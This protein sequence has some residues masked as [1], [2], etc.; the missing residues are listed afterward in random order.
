MTKKESW[1]PSEERI[2]F[3]GKEGEEALR[4]LRKREGETRENMEIELEN[5][6]AQKKEG[7]GLSDDEFF[8]RFQITRRKLEEDIER[9]RSLFTQNKKSKF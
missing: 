6:L 3:G 1:L 8:T 2:M 7:E 5:L 9:I 4:K